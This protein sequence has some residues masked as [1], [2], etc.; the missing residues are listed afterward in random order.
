MGTAPGELR[1]PGLLPF[2]RVLERL[3]VEADHVLFG[4][5]HRTGPL[6]GD[7]LG[8]W[9]TPEGIRL[10]N[11]GSWLNEV[12]CHAGNGASSPYW[13]GTLIEVDGSAPPQIHRLLAGVD[14]GAPTG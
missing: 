2:A 13:P 6:P 3:G 12:A 10:T 8:P 14:L 5:T 7:P 9:T 11:T 4:H 1:R